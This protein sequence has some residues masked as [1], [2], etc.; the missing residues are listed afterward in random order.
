MRDYMQ[1]AG[2]GMRNLVEILSGFLLFSPLVSFLLLL[3]SL[4][5]SRLSPLSAHQVSAPV[6]ALPRSLA[7]TWRID[8]SF[9]SSG[10]LDVSVPPVTS[11]Q[12][13]CS[14]VGT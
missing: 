7:A 3:F 4:L 9:S 12:P 11:S 1:D 6:W 13:M 8:F 14:A 2:F 5:T 10:Y